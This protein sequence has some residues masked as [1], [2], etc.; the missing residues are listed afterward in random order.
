MANEPVRKVDIP[1]LSVKYNG[2][3]DFTT[4]ITKAKGFLE[5]NNLEFIEKKY[6]HKTS[7]GLS[8]IE[9][10]WLFELKVNYYVKESVEVYLKFWDIKDIEILQDGKKTT[11]Q[12][13]RVLVETKGWIDLDWDKRFVGAGKMK[14]VLEELQDLLHKYIIKKAVYGKWAGKLGEKIFNFNRSLRQQ[15]NTETP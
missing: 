11:L 8:E 4:F 13:G 1:V 5:G 9:I 6:K 15:L 14:P 7:D 3:F 2:T 12:N 10:E